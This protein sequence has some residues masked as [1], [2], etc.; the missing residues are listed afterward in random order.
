VGVFVP[1]LYPGLRFRIVTEQDEI[2]E[3]IKIFVNQE[4]VH[5]LAVLLQ[6]AD[7][8]QIICTLSGG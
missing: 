4:Q 6:P 8:I 1:P 2:R 3:H 7:E 5:K